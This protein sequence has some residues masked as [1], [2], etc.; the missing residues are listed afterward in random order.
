MDDKYD[1]AQSSQDPKLAEVNEI[2]SSEGISIPSENSEPGPK[3]VK[4]DSKSLEFNAKDAKARAKVN[5]LEQN[6]K[7]RMIFMFALL[8]LVFL[9]LSAAGFVV[10]CQTIREVISDR[11]IIAFISGITI[12]TLGILTIVAKYLF[13]TKK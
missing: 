12:Q 3:D 13:S 7:L 5:E 11:V 1:L 10:V 2:L 9:T 4:L 8:L 6:N